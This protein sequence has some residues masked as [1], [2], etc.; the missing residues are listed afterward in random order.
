MREGAKTR[1]RIEFVIRES[2]KLFR[3]CSFASSSPS[4]LPTRLHST[5]F[6]NDLRQFRLYVHILTASSSFSILIIGRP[7]DPSAV[8]LHWFGIFRLPRSEHRGSGNSS[9]EIDSYV[10]V[11]F[12]VLG[13]QL[14]RIR[15]DLL[16]RWPWDRSEQR[17]GTRREGAARKKNIRRA[18]CNVYI[19]RVRCTRDKI[20]RAVLLLPGVGDSC[21]L[22]QR[23]CNNYRE[24]AAK[25][26]NNILRRWTRREE[27]WKTSGAVGMFPLLPWR[28]TIFGSHRI[29]RMKRW[30]KEREKE[31]KKA[32][33][34]PPRS[35]YIRAL[36]K[37]QNSFVKSEN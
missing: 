22:S 20:P 4:F 19:F 26:K 27:R 9:L 29:R 24:Y 2:T 31:R 13:W 35:L 18:S 23:K 6:P 12:T 8:V 1:A 14:I 30:K 28:W 36:V 10:V 5:T 11:I 37:V 17:N 33:K 16:D 32:N 25:R 15:L 3:V 21:D 34:A 7:F